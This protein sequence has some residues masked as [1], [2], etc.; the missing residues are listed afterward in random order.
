METFRL[1][2]RGAQVEARQQFAELWE[3][4]EADSDAYPRCLL[5]H[6][7]ADTQHELDDELAWDLTALEIAEAAIEA[8]TDP[9][10]PA[11]EKFLPSLHMNLADGFRKQGDFVRARF[12]ADCGMELGGGLGLDPY[13]QRVRAELIR[14]EAQIADSDSGPPIVFDSE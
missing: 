5:A 1:Y 2:C 10:V 13:G 4:F 8:G 11:V 7:I 9:T 14:I 6:F 3:E 12:H